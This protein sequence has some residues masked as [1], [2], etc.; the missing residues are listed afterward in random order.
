MRRPDSEDVLSELHA[1]AG[2][3]L[4]YAAWYNLKGLDTLYVRDDVSS[5]RHEDIFERLHEEIVFEDVGMNHLETRLESGEVLS[6]MRSFE[7]LLL[8]N[9][10]YGEN[11]GL[12]VSTDRSLD[13][14]VSDF[15][16]RL[17]R[18]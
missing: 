8:F 4:R 14:L 18:D 3:G 11:R 2:E 6:T 17:E 7:A 16:S 5:S 13:V 1:V 9:F 15:L 10:I 12:I